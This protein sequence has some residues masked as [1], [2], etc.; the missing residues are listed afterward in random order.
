MSGLIQRLAQ[1]HVRKITLQLVTALHFLRQCDIIHAGVCL[2]RSRLAVADCRAS[3]LKPENILLA[4]SEAGATGARFNEPAQA[5][6][7]V[8]VLLPQWPPRAHPVRCPPSAG[9]AG[10]RKK[11]GACPASL[12]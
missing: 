5:F 8:P 10:L 12:T 7:E 4:R 6:I 9:M 2:R 3:D 1:P 11:S